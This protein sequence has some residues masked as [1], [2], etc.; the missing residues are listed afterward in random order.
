MKQTIKQLEIDTNLPL[1][2]LLKLILNYAL[3]AIN[4]KA[5]S[6]MTVNYKQKILQIR[7]RLGIPHIGRTEEPFYSLNGNSIASRVV[8]KE[9][10][11]CDNNVTKDPDY[12][13]SQSKNKIKSILSVPIIHKDTVIAVIN[14]DSEKKNYFT[15][16]NQ[17][18]LEKIASKISFLIYER[19]SFLNAF[20]KIS[21]ELLKSPDK[22][23]KDKILQKI[24]DV[25]VK[26]LGIDIVILYEYDQKNNEFIVKG[27]GPKIGGQLQQ[28]NQMTTKVYK[29]D[30]P[31]QIIKKRKPLFC[32]DVKKENF[33]SKR[34]QRAK[35][36]TRP[37][38]IR[39][40]KIK[41]MAALLLPNKAFI[42]KKEE[43]VGVIFANYQNKHE[44][45]ADEKDALAAFADY[46]ALAILNSR[47]E[48]QRT[49]EIKKIEKSKKADQLKNVLDKIA[50]AVI[51][52]FDLNN[53][54]NEILEISMNT[55]Q[56]QAC[57]I[58][59]IIN[60][61]KEPNILKCI[62]GAGFEDNMV[63]KAYY[64]LGEG[65]TGTI[66]KQNITINI[67]NQSELE[68]YKEKGQWKG[69]YDKEKRGAKG[70]FKN[71]IAAPIKI[72][73]QIKGVIKAENKI[74]K[75]NS[76]FT[77]DDLQSLKLIG[78]IIGLTIDNVKL[79]EQTERQL[80]AI[81]AKAA[82]RI[83]NQTANYNEIELEFE[84]EIEKKIISKKNLTA[85]L[86]KFKNTT[87]NLKTMINEFRDFGKPLKLIKQKCS[88][89]KIIND[90]VWLAKP[91]NHINIFTELDHSIP[92]VLIDEN[93]FAESFKE[94]LKN[95]IKA[96]KHKNYENNNGKIN[97]ITKYVTNIHLKE[98]LIIII[99]E[100]NGPGFPENILIFEPFITTDNK[101]IGL[102][103]ASVKELIEKHEGK[104]EYGTSQDLGG[105]F[106]KFT[107]PM[108][109]K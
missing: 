84:N 62:A 70:K 65:L 69:K 36:K 19:I 89:N 98:D 46:A 20:K 17:Q 75:K 60:K 63:D 79:Y 42:D 83:N 15:S 67:K 81:S 95:S 107:I 56:A 94:L 92:D 59:Y 99:I 102:G 9:K 101:S 13:P 40:E 6:L 44:F 35:G 80:Q 74:G 34:I 91:P 87:R 22:G 58:Y 49:Q 55:L 77:D 1:E 11:I 104:I 71:L 50:N 41:S 78:T 27:K 72:K 103:L 5:G 85:I 105:A 73:N 57:S 21:M 2:S 64:K 7:S 32:T 68:K 51:G 86:N 28:K 38:F 31:Y 26:S 88:I 48:K 37:R 66:A 76:C 43:I 16:K 54:L 106:L 4:A 39:R 109:N 52:R 10:S 24:V 3:S 96:V 45:N 93:R 12:A 18:K 14:A 30:V 82:N 90:E 23:D 97:L 8:I 100:D 25:A 61:E 53:V 108:K 29:T 33:L 47:K